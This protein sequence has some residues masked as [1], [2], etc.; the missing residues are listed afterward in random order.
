M[1]P[2]SAPFGALDGTAAPVRN[3]FPF[4][5]KQNTLDH[6]RIVIPVEWDSWGKI[7]ILLGGFDAKVWGES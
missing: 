3:P 4:G 5:H 6:D 1:P 7:A 2:A